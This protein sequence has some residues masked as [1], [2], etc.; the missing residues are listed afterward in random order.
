M[1]LFKDFEKYFGFTK[2]CRMETTFRFGEPLASMST[3]FILKNPEQKEK[4][5][6]P[7]SAKVKT[8]LKTLYYNSLED[9]RKMVASVLS[10]IPNNQSVYLLGRYSFDVDVL[11]SDMFDVFMKGTK[12]FVRHNGKE[13]P[14]LTAHQSKGLEADHVLLIN[15]NSGAYGFPSTISDDPILSRVLSENDHFEFGEERRL[16]YVAITRGKRIT[17]VFYDKKHPST[18]VTEI[19]PDLPLAER[20]PVCQDGRRTMVHSGIAKNGSKFYTYICSNHTCGCD[21]RQT[22]FDRSEK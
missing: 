6:Q 20:C 14:Y 19:E 10:Y 5:V 21:Y 9:Q 15:C 16:F 4:T 2:E 7:Y 8:E 3:G 13:Y 17:Y 22:I 12:T 11:K 18:F 1:A